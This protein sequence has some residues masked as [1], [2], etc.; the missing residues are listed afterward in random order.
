MDIAA[1]AHGSGKSD[2]IHFLLDSVE[3]PPC[4]NDVQIEP[5]GYGTGWSDLSERGRNICKKCLR[6]FSTN[7][8][9]LTPR[10]QSLG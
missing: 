4:A 2:K 10:L 5:D 7:P 6:R 1:F 9:Q 3:L 8:V